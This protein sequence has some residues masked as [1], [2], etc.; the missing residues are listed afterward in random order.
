MQMFGD[1]VM[2]NRRHPARSPWTYVIMLMI[3]GVAY[4]HDYML[5][6]L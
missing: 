5:G 4:L 6:L 3:L 1:E 2:M